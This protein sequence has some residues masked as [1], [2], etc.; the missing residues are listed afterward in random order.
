MWYHLPYPPSHSAAHAHCAT[1]SGFKD[2]V[3]ASA[4]FL[5]EYQLDASFFWAPS[6]ARNLIFTWARSAFIV[7]L[8]A[9][10]EPIFELF[11]DCAGDVLQYL[12]SDMTRAESSRIITHCSSP[13]A[14]YWLRA[15]NVAAI[16][17]SI[18]TLL[19][20]FLGNTRDC[21]ET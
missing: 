17:V 7:H 12:E 15:V 2:F 19:M 5:H 14:Q 10:T 13:K 20:L 3:P 6:K 1:H 18:S 4:L 9:S 16:A 21:H 11:D 8:G